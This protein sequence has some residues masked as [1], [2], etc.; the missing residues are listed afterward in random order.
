MKRRKF[1]SLSAAGVS[2][3][4]AGRFFSGRL[5]GTGP[6]APKRGPN[7]VV[8][9]AD[10]M[11]YAGL[12]VQ[13][14]PDIP[15]PNMDSIAR[16][17]VRF[18]QGYVSCPICAPT[19]AGLMTG[20]YGQRFGFETNPG[21]SGQADEN[22]GLPLEEKTMA[23][24]LKE[25][26]YKT[27]MFGKWHLGYKPER[28][29]S[30]RGFDEFFGFLDG[31][32]PYLPRRGTGRLLQGTAPV[33]EKEYLTDALG[34]E[35]AGFIDRHKDEP[36]FLYVAFNAVHA[37]L[38]AR[39]EYLD[40]FAGIEN[41]TRRT[42]AAMTAALD[43]AV[44][45]ILK[46]LGRWGLERETLVFFLSDNGVPTP[47]TTS[48]NLPYRGFKGQV[49]E[50]GIHVPFM[51][52]WRG[53]LPEGRVDD[54]PV[55]Q[56]DILPTALAVAGAEILPDWKLDG[57]DLVPYLAEGNSKR[58]HEALYWRMFNQHAVRSGDW[59]LVR[60]VAGE[61]AGLYNLKDDPAEKQNR[62]AEMP[63]KAK[64]LDALWQAWNRE[65]A[66][67]RWVRQGPGGQSL[68]GAEAQAAGE[69][70]AARF[71]RWDRNKDGRLT[72]EEVGRPALFKRLDLDGDGVVTLDEARRAMRRRTGR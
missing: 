10:D 56:L 8:L 67:P 11:G 24:R 64:E 7:I 5:F 23:E 41:A 65:L 26:G 33:E 71:K 59:K 52:Q 27:G 49:L 42:H 53:R 2:G 29:P 36:F 9:L 6:A 16:N 63:D 14:C 60:G 43:E 61:A 58:P 57:V 51:I 34:R 50:G 54:R 30:K 68:A 13:G 70:P 72:P 20:R 19:R 18:T 55:I 3:A 31:A 46:T 66:E 4:A 35:A 15:T 69:T 44:G 1:L 40:R 32:H 28:A 17:G 25:R 39:P 38:E 47:Q 48:S 37:P 22:F 62:A 21:P 45:R 12:G